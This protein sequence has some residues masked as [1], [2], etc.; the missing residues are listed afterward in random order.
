MNQWRKIKN[1]NVYFGFAFQH[2]I[3]R[4]GDYNPFEDN[5]LHTV[6]IYFDE[7]SRPAATY[8]SSDLTRVFFS[9]L[10]VI[11]VNVYVS[12]NSFLLTVH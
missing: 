4:D 11:M 8:V 9:L 5:G 10:G 2:D 3:G 7:S 1:S 12:A 6:Y